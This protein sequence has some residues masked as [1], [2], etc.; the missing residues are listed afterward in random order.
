MN[1]IVDSKDDL[2][3]GCNRCVRECPIELANS[4]YQIESGKIKVNINHDRCITC[5]RCIPACKHGARYFHDD[6]ELFFN[7]LKKGVP[8]SLIVAP[9]VKTNIPEHKRL[10][11]YLKQQG[12]NMIYDVTLGADICIWGHVNYIK[13]NPDARL[14]TQPCPVIVSYCEMY[15]HDLLKWLSPVQSPMACLSIYLKKYKGLKDRIA[16]VSPCIAK[17]NEYRDTGLSD[18]NV[19]F[20]GLLKYID[21]NNIKLPKKETEFDNNESGLGALFPLPGGLK[22]NINYF[23]DS[24]LY[25]L[26]SEGFNVYAKLD[27]YGDSNE[28]ILPDVFDVLNCEDGCNIGPA[29][30]HV[31]NV[32]EIDNTMND[33]RVA[34]T[35]KSKKEHYTNVYSMYDNTFKLSDFMRKYKAV[36]TNIPEIAESDIQ[37]AYEILGKKDYEEKNIDCSACGSQTCYDMARKIAL[38]VNIPINCIVKSMKDARTEHENYLATHNQLLEAVE[39]AQKANRAKSEFLANMSHEIRTPMNAIIGMSEILEHETL[40][41]TQANYVRDI[42]TSS[43]SLLRII[44]DILDMSKIESGKLEL[45]PVDYNFN[46]LMDNTVSMLKHISDNRGLEFIY[47]TSEDVPVYLYGDDI[48]LKQ[49]ITNIGGNAVKFTQQGYVKLSVVTEDGN[50]IIKVEDSGIGIRSEDLPKLYQAFEQLDRMRNRSAVG[51][52]LGLPICK[53]LVEMMG[54]NIFAE[55]EYG[56]GTTFT[57]TVPLELGDEKN[58][59]TADVTHSSQR[60]SAPTAKVL[61][62]DDNDFNLRVTS[63]LL[64]LMKIKADTVASGYKAIEAV[65]KKDYDIIFMDQ[66][67]P[68][69]DGIETVHEIRKLGGKYLDINIIALTANAVLGAKE[70]FLENGFDDYIS[71]PVDIDKL[72]ELVIKYLP[73]EKVVFVENAEVTQDDIDKENELHLKLIK[74]F[75]KENKNTYERLIAYIVSGDIRTAHRTAHTL[76]SSAGYLGKR[77]LHK[78]ALSLEK[79]L[80]DETSQHT[81]LQLDI[82]K[83]ELTAALVEF[84]KICKESKDEKIEAKIISD[85]DL[86]ILLE[87]LELLLKKGDISS[88]DYIGQIQGIEGLEKIASLIS[89]YEFTDA[90]GIVRNIRSRSNKNE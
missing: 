85:D 11:T 88:L 78:A 81:Q 39:A 62:T 52:G 84:E 18:Y 67:M 74:T 27:A 58:I 83:R 57:V 51:T 80:H 2:C 46:Q 56:K 14:I 24:K 68:G 28:D 71:K 82:L 31:R 59:H 45:N 21:E 34:A 79:A 15:R 73:V 64:K 47:T 63:G 44:N 60:I 90:L 43:Y 6:T 38:N 87:D 76:K 16:A 55:S 61:V 37:A 89:D 70:M 5:G 25:I 20:T 42:K 41:E 7:D 19:T 30:T 75:V 50:L 66:M 36:S 32:F 26:E 17:A 86:A 33:I 40:D 77:A 12:V 53:S 54:G 65:S 13:N 10:F 35:D 1:S 9:S 48:R 29:S 8:I 4:T 49:I 3:I 22:E 69:M 23:T 72:R